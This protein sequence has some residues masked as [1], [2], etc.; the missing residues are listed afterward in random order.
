M[1]VRD[2]RGSVLA[3]HPRIFLPCL[4][5]VDY[6]D[7]AGSLAQCAIPRKRPV[8]VKHFT[9]RGDDRLV[10]SPTLAFACRSL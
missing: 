5:S 2:A 4:F 3:Y 1:L 10:R 6:G 7:S 8:A 9:Y